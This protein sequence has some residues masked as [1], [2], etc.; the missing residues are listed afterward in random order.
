M[1]RQRRRPHPSL[2]DETAQQRLCQTLNV[3][4]NSDY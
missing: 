1:K 2:R 3:T 4:P